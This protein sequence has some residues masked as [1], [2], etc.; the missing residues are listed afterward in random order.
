MG[1]IGII[2]FLSTCLY[3]GLSIN[4]CNIKLII[5][6]E[7]FWGNAENRTRGSLVRSANTTSVL[8]VKKLVRL[9]FFVAQQQV[10]EEDP[11]GGGP[12]VKKMKIGK[13]RIFHSSCVVCQKS[14]SVFASH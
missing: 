13:M 10:T 1:S 8:C 9:T 11:K 12:I 4:F 3:E 6:R 7:I 2:Q 14:L 5:A